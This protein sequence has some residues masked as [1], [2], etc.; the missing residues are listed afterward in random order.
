MA[1]A[2]ENSSATNADVLKGLRR[3]VTITRCLRYK[4]LYRNRLA[5]HIQANF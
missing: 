5:D 4:H 3:I 2:E 1:H